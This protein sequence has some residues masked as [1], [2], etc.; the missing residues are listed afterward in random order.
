M[1]RNRRV[2]RLLALV[3]LVVVSVFIVRKINH[4]ATPQVSQQQQEESLRTT[5][6]KHP[7]SSPPSPNPLLQEVGEP[8]GILTHIG[9][10]DRRRANATLL[11]LVRNSELRGIVRTM[12]D[13]ERTFNSKFN[14]PWTFFN[15]EPFTEEFKRRTQAMTKA[16]CRYGM[17]DMRF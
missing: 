17:L 10:T 14:Y 9:D 7:G 13:I 5:A 15:D 8:E 6:P 11:S 2:N 3:A 1:P 16:P 4:S 12:Q